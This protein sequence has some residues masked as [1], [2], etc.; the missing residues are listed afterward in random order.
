MDYIYT[1]DDQIIEGEVEIGKIYEEPDFNKIIVIKERE[2]KR[3]R[4]VLDEIN[5][6]E[7][8]LSFVQRKI[9]P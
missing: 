6:N 2:A 5:Q 3:V 7:K 4:V 1:S 8:R 9:M